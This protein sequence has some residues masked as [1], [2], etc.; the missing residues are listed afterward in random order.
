MAAPKIVLYTYHGC[1][2][3]HRAHIALK[4][5]GLD[6][7]EVIID[8]KKP[9]EPWYLEINP[10]RSLHTFWCILIYR[11]C[12]ADQINSAALS[13]V[14]P[15]T[16][17]SSSNRPSSRSSSPTPTPRTSFRPP[18]APRMPFTARVWACSPTPSPAR[19]CRR[20]WLVFG[21]HRTIS[22]M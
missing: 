15:T 14:F 7:E 5:T 1:P 20:L 22:A 3:A 13:P 11:V 16:A 8:L 18:R 10:V 12:G 21:R 2:W 9:R 17:K 6:F 19:S 4:E